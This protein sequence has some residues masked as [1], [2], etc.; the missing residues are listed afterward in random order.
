MHIY[1][2][3]PSTDAPRS[4]CSLTPPQRC[5]PQHMLGG[6][7]AGCPAKLRMDAEKKIWASASM[8]LTG[9]VQHVGVPPVSPRSGG[10]GVGLVGGGAAP[11]YF[12]WQAG[13]FYGAALVI[14]S[15]GG[16]RRLTALGP[17][18]R[19]RAT[20]LQE[21]GSSRGLHLR[22]NNGSALAPPGVFLLLFHGPCRLEAGSQFARCASIVFISSFQN[23][24]ALLAHERGQQARPVAT[25]VKKLYQWRKETRQEKKNMVRAASLWLS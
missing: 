14:H 1:D 2:S 22:S 9:G 20:H 17:T 3:I 24:P 18:R 19:I 8:R 7:D 23:V 25:R 4:S 16:S 13:R 12:T 5:A 10:G 6:A 21:S 15:S 11:L